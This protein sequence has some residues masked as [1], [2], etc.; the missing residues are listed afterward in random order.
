MME[1]AILTPLEHW[2]EEKIGLADGLSREAIAAYQLEML[3]VTLDR[4][5]RY[6]PFYRQH[7]AQAGLKAIYRLD[8]MAAYP[9]TTADDVRRYAAQMLCVSQSEINRV[10][11]LH[12]S[13]TTGDPKRLYFSRADQELTIDFFRC[14]MS[15]LTKAGDKVLILLPGER[16]GSVGDLLAKALERS[17]VL[18]VLYGLVAQPL[19]AVEVMRREEATCLVGVPVQVLAMARCWEQ[20][21]GNGWRPQQILLST[22]HVPQIVAQEL[23]RI[24]HCEVYA[25]YG[26]TEM[27]LGGGIECAAQSGYH[28]R[29]ADL[30]FEIIDP[31]SLRPVPDGE[32]GELVFTTLTR[33]GMPL[34]RYRT[35]DLSRFIIEPC[36]CGSKLRRLE[37]VRSRIDG[38]ASLTNTHEITMADLDEALFALPEV[39]DFSA[40]LTDKGMMLLKLVV[41]IRPDAVSFDER[42]V[43]RSL[44]QLDPIRSTEQEGNLSLAVEIIRQWSIA[45]GKRSIAVAKE[46]ACGAF[47]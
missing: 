18:S 16:P 32:Y 1:K 46:R 45:F 3:N 8:D 40:Q 2:I 17:G 26:M 36:P 43:L 10:V 4:V 7:L 9:F 25:H 5:L 41:T 23:K 28:L 35:G 6:S 22:D 14:G 30:Y 31:F 47:E 39:V 27:G 38:I 19:Q 33:Q 20:Q 37:R 11:T 13:G 15:T 21:G 42:I 44:R 24:W 12:T 34:I 29:E